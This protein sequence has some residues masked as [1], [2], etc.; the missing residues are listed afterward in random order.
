MDS[1]NW[2]N[3]QL[4][5]SWNYYFIFELYFLNEV[6]WDNEAGTRTEQLYA[7][8]VLS[9]PCYP[10]YKQCVTREQSSGGPMM[11]SARL[12]VHAR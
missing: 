6:Q 5:L 4:L 1:G 12:S 10:I 3:A 7:M 11:L 8:H 9:V 2:F